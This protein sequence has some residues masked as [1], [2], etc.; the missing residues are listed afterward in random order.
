MQTF[1]Q[2][3]E[4]YQTTEI[5]HR[6]VFGY[7]YKSWEWSSSA[8]TSTLRNVSYLTAAVRNLLDGPSRSILH[9]LLFVPG[10]YFFRLT[11][12][13]QTC[14][15]VLFPRLQQALIAAA[16]DY[17]TFR[18]AHRMGGP[19]VAWLATLVNLSNLYT[20]FTATR[21]FSNSTEAAVTAAALFYWPYVP[22]FSS[23]FDVSTFSTAEERDKLR[24]LQGPGCVWQQIARGMRGGVGRSRRSTIGIYIRSRSRG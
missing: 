2:P 10:Y 3:D 8:D 14:L 6:L 21:T 12:L 5:A 9:P 13:D 19:V 15:L 22:F 16:G 4:H 24:E 23:R 18:L 11:G 7:G 20:L 1:F 17:Y